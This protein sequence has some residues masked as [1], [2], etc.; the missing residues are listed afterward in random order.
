[1]AVTTAA[2]AVATTAENG[3]DGCGVDAVTAASTDTDNNQLKVAAE[4]GRR[5]QRW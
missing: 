1:M 5:W 2:K 4:G 3:G